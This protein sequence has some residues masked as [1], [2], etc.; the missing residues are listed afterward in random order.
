MTTSCDAV[1]P[2]ATNDVTVTS[3]VVTSGRRADVVR[4][5]TNDDNVVPSA[6]VV[7]KSSHWKIVPTRSSTG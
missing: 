6:G 4:D 2:T 1:V 3:R 7:K 5:V